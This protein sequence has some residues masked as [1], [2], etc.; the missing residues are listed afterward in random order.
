M[1]LHSTSTSNEVYT[2][3]LWAQIIMNFQLKIGFSCGN[4]TQIGKCQASLKN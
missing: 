2:L 4:V 3:G 1:K